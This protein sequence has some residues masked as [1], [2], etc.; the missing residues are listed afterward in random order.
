MDKVNIG[1]DSEGIS[2]KTVRSSIPFSSSLN[3]PGGGGKVS[4]SPDVGA[5]EVKKKS[6]GRPLGS[7]GAKKR[8]SSPDIG[9]A[10]KAEAVAASSGVPNAKSVNAK[11]VKGRSDGNDDVDLVLG[12]PVDINLPAQTEPQARLSD[13]PLPV[14]VLDVIVVDAESVVPSVGV[15]SAAT[16]GFVRREYF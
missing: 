13:L 11:A 3:S 15:A 8:E 2:G 16:T 10:K 4:K 6:R 5:S 14:T 1:F 7:V 12:E 9:L